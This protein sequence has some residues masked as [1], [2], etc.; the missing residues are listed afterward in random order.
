MARKNNPEQ[1]REKIISVSTTLFF[2]K[3]YEQ[4][5]MQDIVNDLGMS[6]GAIFHHFKSKEEILNGVMDTQSSAVEDILHQWLSEMS[7]RTA[8]EKLIGILEKNIA[9]Q[10]MHSLDSVLASQVKNPWFIVRTMQDAV[11]KSAPIFSKIMREGNEE[12][13]ITT[14]YPDECAEVFFLLINVWYDPNIFNCNRSKL[15]KRLKFLQ[16]M[17]KTMGVDIVSDQLIEKMTGFIEGHCVGEWKK[18]VR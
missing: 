17:M 18:D 15:N 3:G 14:D 13:T 7:G 12:G 9:T 11:K 10:E 6:K 1:T 4:T 8:K 2:E 16:Q 5:T